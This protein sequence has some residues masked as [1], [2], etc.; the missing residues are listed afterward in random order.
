M[1]HM[2][3]Q[4]CLQLCMLCRH[5]Q[6]PIFTETLDVRDAAAIESL[7]ARLPEEFAEVDILVNNAGLALGTAAV[8][9]IN[10][11]VRPWCHRAVCIRAAELFALVIA[12]N[13]YSL[14]CH[15]SP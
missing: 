8:T 13:Q 10:T 12:G 11:E 5:L 7:P 15:S 6:V 9:E 4:G 1:Q 3:S 14:V 2:S